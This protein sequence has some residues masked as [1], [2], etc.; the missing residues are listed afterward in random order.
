[1]KKRLRV[2]FLLFKL[3]NLTSIQFPLRPHF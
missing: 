2:F 1:M 3:L